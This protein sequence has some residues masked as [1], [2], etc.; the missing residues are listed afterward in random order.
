MNRLK[1]LAARAR[2]LAHDR[3]AAGADNP[4]VAERAAS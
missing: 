1:I 4:T 2:A 3:P